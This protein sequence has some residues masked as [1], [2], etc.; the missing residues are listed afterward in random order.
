MAQKSDTLIT[1]SFNGIPTK[2]ISKATSIYKIFKKDSTTWVRTTSD[3]NFVIV[4]KESFSDS[5]F[6]V[7][8]GNYVEYK[9]GKTYLKGYYI[10]NIKQ[11]VWLRYDSTGQAVDSRAYVGGKL[12]GPFVRYW[13]NA[14]ILEQA[15]YIDNRFV[16]ERKVFYE[17]GNLA[18]KEVYDSAHKLIDSTYLTINGARTKKQNLEKKPIFGW[19]GTFPSYVSHEIHDIKAISQFDRFTYSISFI[20]DENG[21]VS[22]V[23]LD[24]TSIPSVGK[25]AVRI[26]KESPKWKP[27]TLLGKPIASDMS[28]D[29]FSVFTPIN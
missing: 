26:V 2:K 16:G 25:E 12:N 18:I 19:G 17:N 3:K 5:A 24:Q 9:S 11:G 28:I 1:Y 22:D 27:G 6:T 15:N 13:K 21:L 8:N 10:Q 4:K 23:R 20:V 29:I 7:L 14:S